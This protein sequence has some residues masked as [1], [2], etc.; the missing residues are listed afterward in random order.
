MLSIMLEQL[1]IRNLAI[2]ETVEV[3]FSGGLNVITGETGAGKSLLVNALNLILGERADKTLIRAG[4][5]DCTVEGEFALQDAAA[6]DAVLEALGVAPCEDGRLII[7]R[8]ISSSGSGR[9]LVND[10]STTLQTLK[11]LGSLLVDLHGPHD[12]QSL[13]DQSFQLQILDSYAGTG[14]LITAYQRVYDEMRALQRERQDLAGEN[15]AEVAQRIDMLRFQVKEIDDAELDGIDEEELESELTRVANATRIIELANGVDTILSGDEGSVFDGVAAVQQRLS[16][17]GDILGED[18]KAW[19]AEAQSIA[20]QVQELSSAVAGMAQSIEYDSDRL[21]WLE[22]R[23]ALLYK[24]KRKYGGSLS[25]IMETVSAAREK[26][27]KLESREARLDVIDEEI[28]KVRDRLE[29][30]GAALR[31]SRAKAARKLA[32]Q[33]TGHL[34]DL[35]FAHGAFD[36]GLES[37]EPTRSGLDLAEYGFAPNAGEPMRALRAIASSGEISRVMLA[38]KAVLAG[39]DRVPVLVF[40]EIDANVGGEMGRA[41]GEKM[42]HVSKNHQVLCIT[43]L[44]QVAVHGGAHFV[45][46]KQVVNERTTTGIQHVTSDARIDE[47]ARMLG[48]R[49]ST[50]VTLDH[51]REM[52]Q[53]AAL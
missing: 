16:E 5:Q 52:L 7:R 35:G 26:L 31:A 6:V 43:H 46:E 14:N 11:R 9:N 22:D 2:A 29:Q 28:R 33:V 8:V 40:D 32:K 39:H 12:H 20:V 45:V 17:L 37:A 44:P 51:A 48:G 34:R 36:V 23:K 41:I 18:A 49:E 42:A 27:A 24:L 4:A 19:Q 38:I 50:S 53:T 30:E 3:Q 1:K 10:S 47:I 15:D 13:L 25:A 21:Q